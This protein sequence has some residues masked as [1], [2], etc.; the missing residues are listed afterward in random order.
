V[1]RDLK[2]YGSRALNQQHGH[3]QRWWTKSGSR[4]PLRAEP[5]VLAAIRY[6]RDQPQPLLVWMER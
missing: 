6:V 4:R 1:L 5:N 3:P 2:R